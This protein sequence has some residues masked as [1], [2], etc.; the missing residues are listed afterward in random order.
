MEGCHNEAAAGAV[1]R[2]DCDEIADLLTCGTGNKNL[3]YI[4]IYE[5]IYI[6]TGYAW[7]LLWYYY[8]FLTCIPHRRGSFRNGP[9]YV[10]EICMAKIMENGGYCRHSVLPGDVGTPSTLQLVKRCQDNIT[11]SCFRTHNTVWGD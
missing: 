8:S 9:L 1:C 3:I 10:N 4:Y 2:T 7:L 6:H 5:Y 11:C